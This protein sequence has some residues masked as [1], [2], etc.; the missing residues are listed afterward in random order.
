MQEEVN[1]KTIALVIKGG[2][3]SEQTLR[4]ALR[5]LLRMRKEHKINRQRQDYYQEDDVVVSKGKQSL[6]DLQSQ[7][8][9]LSNVEITDG[10]IKGFDRYARKYGVDY[11]LKKD[12]HTEPPR[13]YIF[14]K[15]RDS[16]T[17]EAAFKEYAS[18]KKIRG[19]DRPSVRAKLRETIK[20]T[21]P[22]R[23]RTREKKRE[24]SE[25]L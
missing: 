15:A 7:G 12:G 19:K 14:F 2:K 6:K 20:R 1:Q 24:R 21:I 23:E 13:Y 16:K 8:D 3:V 18:V 11:S 9:E 17:M 10:N 4:A 25:A 5:A 22:H